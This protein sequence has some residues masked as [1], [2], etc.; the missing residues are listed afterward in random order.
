M[1]PDIETLIV[2]W[3]ATCHRQ[4]GL[5]FEIHGLRRDC[6]QIGYDD[7]LPQGLRFDWTYSWT[8]HAADHHEIRIGLRGVRRIGRH[9]DPTDYRQRL[10]I[11]ARLAETEMR[12]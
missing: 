11:A 10:T 4:L 9:V 6:Y 12:R 5:A 7:A 3:C 8:Q 2:R 1:G